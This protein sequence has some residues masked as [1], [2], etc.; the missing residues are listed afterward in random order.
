MK[1]LVQPCKDCS[2]KGFL[3]IWIDNETNLNDFYHFQSAIESNDKQGEKT[4]KTVVNKFHLFSNTYN[5]G[6]SLMDGY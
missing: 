6:P 5:Y 3:F 2:A 4:A 1:A